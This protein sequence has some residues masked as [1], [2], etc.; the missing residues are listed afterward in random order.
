[1]T[2]H[3]IQSKELI[4]AVDMGMAI[5]TGGLSA[6]VQTGLDH[7]ASASKHEH[8]RKAAANLRSKLRHEKELREKTAKYLTTVSA[9][10]VKT[11]AKPGGRESV[12]PAVVPELRETTANVAGDIAKL[13]DGM[14][15]LH[16]E[17]ENAYANV[18]K[19]ITQLMAEKQI[20]A[21]N[22]TQFRA[23]VA[24]RFG[25]V[26]AKVNT[27]EPAL[28]GKI[29]LL[30]SYCE[31]QAAAS[32]TNYARLITGLANAGIYSNASGMEA[33]KHGC[34]AI[35]KFRMP[36]A[37]LILLIQS[38]LSTKY[39]IQNYSDSAT[40]AASAT[41]DNLRAYLLNTKSTELE[42]RTVV[43]KGA[44]IHNTVVVGNASYLKTLIM[45]VAG[46]TN[47]GNP[48]PPAFIG[49]FP[50]N[51]PT[52]AELDLSDPAFGTVTGVK[53]KV[54]GGV[55]S[56]V[57]ARSGQTDPSILFQ[58][59][60]VDRGIMQGRV[61]VTMIA[62][63]LLTAALQNWKPWTEVLL[64]GLQPLLAGLTGSAATGF[65]GVEA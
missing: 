10:Q 24:R 65:F 33:L 57:D 45:W 20:Q 46:Y 17:Q 64:L 42:Y 12:H 27:L 28:N 23:Y 47:Q 44:V 43:G 58:S 2:S 59:T 21:H 50:A 52:D 35:G 51:D 39:V 13:R 40:F 22:D 41:V 7:R 4:M 34:L 1:V 8:Q 11:A 26:E 48:V 5:L 31:K 38:H 14:A 25:A 60:G 61:D 56:I 32:N 19:S 55:V 49:A 18:K 63:F 62:N 37:V 29:S 16:E 54:A 36:L 3:L 6:A 15:E 53:V 30:Q 9:G